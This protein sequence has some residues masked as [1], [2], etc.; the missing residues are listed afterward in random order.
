MRLTQMCGHCL[1]A[2][3]GA[4]ASRAHSIVIS[5][6]WLFN[7]EYAALHSD[8]RS[9]WA[10]RHRAIW[11]RSIANDDCYYGIDRSFQSSAHEHA[12]TTHMHRHL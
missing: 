5:N 4:D 7:L 11:L 2:G 6:L 3:A 12:G 1:A 10:V 9:R 8:G